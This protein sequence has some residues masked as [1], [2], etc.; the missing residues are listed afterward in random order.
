MTLPSVYPIL[1]LETLEARRCDAAAAAEGLLEAGAEIVQWR[2]K[3]PPTRRAFAAAD[4]VAAL[5]R[6]SGA[7]WILNDR[8][9][10]ALM[11]EAGLH[12]G[13]EDLPAR[14]ARRLLG[15]AA[16][17]GLSTH[18]ADQLSRAN[19]APVDYVALG[20]VFGTTSKLKPDPV[21]GVEGLREWRKLTRMPLVAIGGITRQN[22]TAVFESGADSVAVISDL[23]PEPCNKRA[24][25]E[26]MEEWLQLSKR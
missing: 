13:Q 25:R 14:E 21:V 11:L 24:I 18:N 23:Y 4:R 3:R 22:A 6:R 15:S 17:L 26:R 10:L 1:D 20:P 8:A 16:I 12:I 7:L 5:C 2:D 19:E 9:D